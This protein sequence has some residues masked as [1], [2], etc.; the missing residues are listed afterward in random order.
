MC[1]LR[2][3]LEVSPCLDPGYYIQKSV[4]SKYKLGEEQDGGLSKYMKK[5]LHL[6]MNT[7]AGIVT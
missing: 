5:G 4:K 3:S 2:C 6:P 1:L 7:F